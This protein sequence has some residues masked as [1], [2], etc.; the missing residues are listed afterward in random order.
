MAPQLQLSF[1]RVSQPLPDDLP[2][3]G[4]YEDAKRLAETH[5]CVVVLNDPASVSDVFRGC[6]GP[7]GTFTKQNLASSKQSLAVR[8]SFRDKYSAVATDGMTH[9]WGSQGTGDNEVLFKAPHG[10]QSG[11]RRVVR[12][13]R[14]ADA[15]GIATESCNTPEWYIL[16]IDSKNSGFGGQVLILEGDALAAAVDYAA[17]AKSVFVFTAHRPLADNFR[18]LDR[19]VNGPDGILVAVAFPLT[20]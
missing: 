20:S 13:F 18:D 17:K 1:C 5:R 7:D 4:T 12:S 3:Q 10:L 6:I 8:L 15:A 9:V 14:T 19:V 16:S 2:K 11:G